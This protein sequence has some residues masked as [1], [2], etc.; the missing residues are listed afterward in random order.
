MPID[1]FVARELLAW[2]AVTP[3]KKPS[4][5]VWAT[6]ANRAE[7][8]RGK[9]PVWLSTVR[10]VTISRRWPESWASRRRCRGIPLD[11]HFPPESHN[12]ASD[13]V[14]SQAAVCHP[15]PHSSDS[16]HHD[17]VY[18]RGSCCNLLTRTV[19]SFLYGSND[20]SVFRILCGEPDYCS[21][22]NLGP[23]T[24]VALRS[25]FTSTRSATLI[26]GMPLFIP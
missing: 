4:D 6:D 24:C 22:A 8:K 26:K 14:L 25:I 9:Q 1:E 2:H 20:A 3:Y 12:Y 19:L 7:A 23:L 10:C 5:Y 17:C 16:N 11:T 13:W 15:P 21:Y 18:E